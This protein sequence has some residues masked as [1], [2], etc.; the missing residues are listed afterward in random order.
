MLLCSRWIC[1]RD[2][3]SVSGGEDLCVSLASM[4]N[5]CVKFNGFR[6]KMECE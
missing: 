3:E 5:V 4:H 6:G 2:G 1:G